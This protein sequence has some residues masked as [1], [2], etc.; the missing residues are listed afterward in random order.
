MPITNADC[1]VWSLDEVYLKINANRW[2]C[3][4]P[5]NDPGTLWQIGQSSTQIPGASWTEISAGGV[6]FLARKTDCTLWSFGSNIAGQLGDGTT[7]S[8]SSPV[9]VPG[10]SWSG[11][12]GGICHSLARKSDGTLWAWGC[13][14]LGELGIGTSGTGLI[15]ASPVQV[16]GT[17]WSGISGGYRFSLARKSDGTL[18]SWGN[19]FNG[20]LGNGSGG[21]YTYRSS[22]VQ[23]PGTSWVE[24]SAGFSTSFARKS[25]GTLWSW[26]YGGTGQLGNGTNGIAVCSPI[27]VSGTSWVEVSSNGRHAIARKSDGTIWTWGRGTNGE[28]GI[29]TAV[30]RSA[31]NQVPGILWVD[32]TAG[33]Y[34]S[35]ARKSDGTLWAWGCNTSGQ[36]GDG[37]TI[38]RSSPVQVPGST[39]IDISINRGITIARKTN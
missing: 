13:N 24:V 1:G 11:I 39:W 5:A 29:G 3:Y 2:V 23:V 25:D 34:R 12:S 16:P 32:A 38:S 19:G 33:G 14:G 15:G 28:L 6:H 37:T 27:N 22:P 21:A 30:D 10:T 4:N 26:G 36:L 17:S 31:P 8:R 18:W 35:F 7:I 20:Q 9:Q